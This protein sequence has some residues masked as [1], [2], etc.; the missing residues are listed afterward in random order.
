[1]PVE[2][3]E[4]V[5]DGG[6]VVTGV[7]VGAAVE[8]RVHPHQVAEVFEPVERR[9]AEAIDADDLGRDPL[10]DLGLVERVREQHQ[11]R[12]TVHVDE[13]RRHD[14]AGHVDAPPDV[15]W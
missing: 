7:R 5:G 6:P 8:A 10:A 13:A 1:M 15:L 14:A 9:V 4:V 11:A 2:P 12:V 3:V